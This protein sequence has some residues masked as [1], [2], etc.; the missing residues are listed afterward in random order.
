MIARSFTKR[1]RSARFLA[2][3]VAG[4]LL[5]TTGGYT[6]NGSPL[7]LQQT[8]ALPGVQDRIDH[9]ALDLTGN[10]HQ[11]YAWWLNRY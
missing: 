8:I 11:N 6:D 5:L 7:R 2:A 4:L 3:L 10:R 1:C 9:M